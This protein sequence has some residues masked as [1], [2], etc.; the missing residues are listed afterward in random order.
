MKIE[1]PQ[2]KD[3]V[4][5][6]RAVKRYKPGLMFRMKVELA[7]IFPSY[8][9]SVAS[10][11][12]ARHGWGPRSEWARPQRVLAVAA[13]A[14]AAAIIVFSS[15]M[16]ASGGSLPGS[17]L[18]GL[19]RAREQ[20][21]LAFTFSQEAKAERHLE[22]ASSRLSELDSMAIEGQ[23][24]TAAAQQ[25]AK[26]YNSETA[27]VSAI[28]KENPADP[29]SQA[30]ARR[31]QAVQT[32]KVNMVRRLAAESPAG[33]LAAADGAQV[34]VKDAGAS[35]VLGT[36]G[37][38][39]G[40]TDS[41][42]DLAVDLNLKDPAQLSGLDVVIQK[43]GRKAVVPL[44]SSAKCG[45][46]YTVNVS[47]DVKTVKLN[48]PTKFKI[49]ISKK[50][51]SPLASRQVKLA[52]ASQT[53][54]ID[55]RSS[56]AVLMTDAN[57]SATFSLAK[58]EDAYSSRL[59]LK[60]DDGVWVDAGQ[61]MAVGAV[62]APS[63]TSA[64]GVVANTLGPA[65]DPQSVE[66][67]N[68]L[69]RLT[70][71]RNEEGKV[72]SSLVRTGGATGA[73]PLYDPL[74]AAARVT[75]G[76]VGTEGPRLTFSNSSAASYETVISMVRNGTSIKKKYQV[77]LSA[78]QKFA[79][80][81]CEV[82]VTGNAAEVAKV[83]PALLNADAL[84]KPAGATLQVSGK[85]VTALESP[86][87]TMLA[88]EVGSPYV[89]FVTPSDV[90]YAAY[91]I[92]SKAYPDSWS[93]T[94]DAIVPTFRDSSKFSS[95]G[96]ESMMMLGVTDRASLDSAISKARSGLGD[97]AAVAESTTVQ[98]ADGFEV[99]TIPVTDQIGKGKQRVTLEVL[100]QYEKV[101]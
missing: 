41:N 49:S 64:S 1:D 68:G 84:A 40:T 56:E 44:T 31:L 21:G 59:G 42:G 25:I 8:G 14:F 83:D 53:S 62:S 95:G 100:K 87:G 39:Q 55:G 29:E 13:M 16:L 85:E 18:Y 12:K 75:G 96:F 2:D 80:V 71:D 77:T 54:L 81:K 98:S 20:L 61:V 70:A 101:L 19:K 15:L 33:V 26:A 5:K 34:T 7:A 38:V 50:D 43:D 9:L 76:Q 79:A 97:P 94:S 89:A 78:G 58:T 74:P 10:Q 90:V 3:I 24:D 72:V 47:P 45:G 52:D 4:E 82:T 22:L 93:V 73:G 27:A 6:I 11:K 88:F 65:E 48:Q 92:D 99:V 28:L 36:A 86:G 67:D 37:Q 91:P 46:D 63:A 69:V 66:L 51:G 35:G 57:G 30:I 32:Q 17:P 60:I 23:V